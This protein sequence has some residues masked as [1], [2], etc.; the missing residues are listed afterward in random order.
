MWPIFSWR[1][2]GVAIGRLRCALGADRARIIR[3][4]LTESVLLSL[5]GAVLGLGLAWG[6]VRVLAS[7]ESVPLPR[8]N[9]IGLDSTVLLFTFILSLLVGVLFGF[10]PTLQVSQLQLSEELKASAQAVLHPVGRRR[11]LRHALVVGEIATALALL[12]GA[13]L[14]LRSLAKM[15]EVNVGAQPENVLTMSI[16]LPA[17]KYSTLEQQA[18]FYQ[19]LLDRVKNTPGVQAASVSGA[20]PLE[21]IMNGYISGAGQENPALD[22]TLVE[23][24]YI[25]TDYF[26]TFG[27]PF[28]K[29]RDFSDQDF[30]VTAVAVLKIDALWKSHNLEASRDIR[31]V[32]VI[33]QTMG[34][35]FWPQQ[36]PVGRTFTRGDNGQYTVIGVVGDV[37]ERGVRRPVIPQAYY[38]LPEALNEPGLPMRL[39]I[40]SAGGA[41]A[42]LPTVRAKV[43]ALDSGL[44]LSNVRTMEDVITTS[45]T[46]AGTSYQTLLLG[47]FALLALV[48]TAVGIYGVMAYA[49]S[50]RRHE[51]GLRIALGAPRSSILVLVIS[52]GAKLTLAG[53]AI[54]LVGAYA[55]TR[56][57][58]SL[59]YGIRTT[60]PVTFA[61]V[62]GLLTAVALL[63]CY[64]PARRATKVDPMQA[65]RCE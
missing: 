15:R 14:L 4:L 39:A 49:V 7:A 58:S 23:F 31:K 21:H 40:R 64:V 26:R 1:A 12:I 28:V 41:R 29:G 44:A 6:C 13:G 32:T 2:P 33:N 5:L 16:A 22:Q 48:L 50:Q 8:A 55:L 11:F 17:R 65:L 46:M 27:I 9:P 51:I 52:Q 59:V 45:I 18:T 61:A 54:G 37:N 3:Q 56:L 53:V 47:S 43:R 19:Q 25:S 38:P 20:I 24:N 42:V 63:A 10:A 62:A 36:D 35:K 34:R 60:D 57:M 30:K